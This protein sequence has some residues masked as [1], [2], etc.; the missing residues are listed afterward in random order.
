M[1]SAWL[2]NVSRPRSL[3]QCQPVRRAP[4]RRQGQLQQYLSCPSGNFFHQFIGQV[5][6]T[7]KPVNRFS[8]MRIPL[9]SAARAVLCAVHDDCSFQYTLNVNGTTQTWVLDNLR[10]TP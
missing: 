4:S 3:T 1:L 8:P 5:D 6:L 7:G 9:T 10:F 2:K